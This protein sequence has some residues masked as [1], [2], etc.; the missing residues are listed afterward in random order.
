LFPLPFLFPPAKVILT[1]QQFYHPCAYT[2]SAVTLATLRLLDA[3]DGEYVRVGICQQYPVSI[4]IRAGDTMRP[5]QFYLF[6]RLRGRYA[7]DAPFAAQIPVDTPQPL[8]LSQ[9]REK[10]APYIHNT[11]H[12]SNPVAV[13]VGVSVAV[14]V[15][16]WVNV[17]V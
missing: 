8:V 6:C 15:G 5:E 13:I 9:L 17:E 2:L 10:V 4:R 7:V 11:G 1:K 12:G 3:D 16:V 14:G